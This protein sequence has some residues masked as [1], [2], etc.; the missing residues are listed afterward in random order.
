MLKRFFGSRF[1]RDSAILQVSGGLTALSS[2]IS[3]AVIAGTIGAD[4][5]GEYITA[6]SLYGLFF[7][8]FNTGVMQATVTQLASNLAHGRR[9][10]IA[11]WLAFLVKVYA[12]AGVFLLAVG[13]LV[14]PPLGTLFGDGRHVGVMAWWLCASPLLELPRVVAA[15]TFQAARRMA[16]LARLE[17]RT[18]FARLLL[19]CSGALITGDARGP[20][21]GTVATAG[22]GGVLGLLAYRRAARGD[23]LKLPSPGFIIGHVRDVPLRQGLRLSLRIGA[24]RSLDALAFNILPP[25]FIQLA[26]RLSGHANTDQWVSYFRIAQRVMQIPVIALQGISRTALPALS[27]MAGRRDAVGFERAFQRVTIVSGAMT[28]L[29]V[30]IALLLVR[31][32]VEWLLPPEYHDP[33]PR[34]CAILAMGYGVIGFSVAF[35]SYYIVT[36]QLKLALRLSFGS[37]AIS[38]P[39]L[40]WLCWLLPESG[41]AWGMVL[42]Y[43]YTIVHLVFMA[44]YFRSGRMARVWE[45]AAPS[46]DGSAPGAAPAGGG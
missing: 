1:F 6:I 24:L 15:A 8:L 40:F 34:L 16:D 25:L 28:G 32:P 42:N 11:S 5:Q 26:G 17:V 21:L 45:G 29:G 41:A 36:D 35:D 10:K 18:E 4:Q 22:V 39:A 9:E 19:V 46:E 7:M 14:L 44:R 27:Q 30:L 23:E 38:L 20:V 31:I 3:V 37:M 13:W 33:V 12:L 2:L 43:S